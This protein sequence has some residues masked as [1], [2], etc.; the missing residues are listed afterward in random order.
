VFLKNLHFHSLGKDISAN[1]E[2]DGEP[3]QQRQ[4][5]MRG[6]VNL[7]LAHKVSQHGHIM[8]IKRLAFGRL[9]ILD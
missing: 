7:G 4:H 3:N 9:N 1:E 2:G 5:H 8:S 6:L